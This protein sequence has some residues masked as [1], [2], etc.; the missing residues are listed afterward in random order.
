MR[1]F[2][3]LRAINVGGRNVTMDELRGLLTRAKFKRVES[4]IASGNLVL[5]GPDDDTAAMQAKIEATLQQGL[6]YAV[7]TFL[8]RHDDLVAM[9][10][11]RP[12]DDATMAHEGAYHVGL[13]H[14]PLGAAHLAVLE[15]LRNDYDSFA[16]HGR[17]LYWKCKGKF[18]DSPH[19]DDFTR[20]V[21]VLHTFRNL[22][23]I[24][25]LAAKFPPIA[26]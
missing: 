17:E 7:P 1:Y 3:F 10:A 20:R 22:N 9:I 19:F 18:S 13:L 26:R 25:R 21:K 6:G 12:F 8:R 16:A 14:E 4:F 23:T 11:H 24:T 15:S 2:A 5:D